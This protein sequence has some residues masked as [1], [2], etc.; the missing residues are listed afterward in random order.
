MKERG[1]YRHPAR[2]RQLLLFDG[3][4]YGNI[5]PTDI[6]ATIEYKDRARIFV[7][8]KGKSKDVPTG[9]RLLL[10]RFVDDF[11]ASGKD[12]IAIIAEHGVEDANQDV[13]LKDCSVREIYYKRKADDTD[14]EWRKPHGAFTVKQLTDA[15]IELNA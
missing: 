9:Q 5:T 11:R 4:Q 12:A 14:C 15:F 13:H 3:M 10:Q 7:E 8:V 6:D 1:V 2:A